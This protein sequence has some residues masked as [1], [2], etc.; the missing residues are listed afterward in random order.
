MSG[1]QLTAPAAT[2]TAEEHADWLELK[3]LASTK[4]VASMEDL[5]GAFRAIGSTDALNDEETDED[6]PLPDPAAID[7]GS[8]RA[9]AVAETAFEAID[10]RSRSVKD[11]Q[12][13]PFEVMSG[14]IKLKRSTWRST[15][16][17]LLLLT[18]FGERSSPQG[19]KGASLFEAVSAE[20]A[21][22]YLGGDATGAVAYSFGFP[23]QLAPR[24][25]REALDDM[26]ARMEEGGGAK[27]HPTQRY[28]KDAKLDIAVWLPMPDSRTGKVIG[29]GQ[30]ATGGNWPTKVGEMHADPWCKK[31]MLESPPVTPL[32]FFF[33]PHRIVADTW[34]HHSHDAGVVFDRCRIAAF[35]SE[36]PRSIRVSME[37]WMR[38]NRAKLQDSNL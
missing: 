35:A 9:Q 30:C 27:A 34:T 13:Y 23:R 8:E 5:V 31:W 36:L 19:I 7:R 12:R 14:S 37:A 3:A 26:C 18:K 2:A 29:F 24:N 38:H 15:Y 22:N 11:P 20:A 33:V 10:E 4:R 6:A 16:T 17:Y 21:R 1:P 28:Q 25:F 32:R